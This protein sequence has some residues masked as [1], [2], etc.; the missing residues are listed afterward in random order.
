MTDEVQRDE[1]GRIKPEGCNLCG[2][3]LEME[4]CNEGETIYR[5][6]DATCRAKH[7]VDDDDVVIVIQRD[8]GINDT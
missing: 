8:G 3:F 7:F 2:Y 5:C 6:G 4:Y 1:R